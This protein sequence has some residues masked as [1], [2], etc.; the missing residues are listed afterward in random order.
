MDDVET[1]HQGFKKPWWVSH[2][3]SRR[4]QPT[5]M[6]ASNDYVRSIHCR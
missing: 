2:V 3:P 1:T 4:F 6:K 5:A